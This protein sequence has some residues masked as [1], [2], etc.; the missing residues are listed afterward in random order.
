M[1]EQEVYHVN[2]AGVE[3]ELRKMEVAPGVKIAVLNIL[4][5][6]ELVQAAAKALAKLMPA[7][8]QYIVQVRA[9]GTAG[10]SDWSDAAMLMAA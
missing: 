5:D 2:I 1:S 6:T 3:R 9:I 10:P 8:T 4:G 7:G